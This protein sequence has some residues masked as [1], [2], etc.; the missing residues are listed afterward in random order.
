MKTMQEIE[1]A[2][3]WLDDHFD[4]KKPEDFPRVRHKP[5]VKLALMWVLDHNRREME[6]YKQKGD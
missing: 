2:L 5:A 4:E 1:Q 3:D 6:Q